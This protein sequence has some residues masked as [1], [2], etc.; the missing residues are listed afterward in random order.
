MSLDFA[1]VKVNTIAELLSDFSNINLLSELDDKKSTIAIRN[2]PWNKV[3][4]AIIKANAL[5]TYVGD[6]YT[7]IL[8]LEQIEQLSRKNEKPNAALEFN[9]FSTN[10]IFYCKNSKNIPLAIYHQGIDA[11]NYN[12][13][14]VQIGEKNNQYKLY[15][16]IKSNIPTFIKG[17][18]VIEANFRDGEFTLKEGIFPTSNMITKDIFKC[19]YSAFH[20]NNF[21]EYSNLKLIT[22]LGIHENASGYNIKIRFNGKSA[23][24]KAYNVESRKLILDFYDV[25]FNTNKRNNYASSIKGVNVDAITNNKIVR[26]II[27]LPPKQYHFYQKRKRNSLSID[28]ITRKK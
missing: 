17:N 28:V 20:I 4:D 26:F 16:S 8:P 18:K 25:T 7:I 5:G 9:K 23:P 10:L 14:F 1:E 21:Q 19:D 2:T 27:T 15:N 3:N 13:L 24:V 11:N 12:E 6:K 22:Y